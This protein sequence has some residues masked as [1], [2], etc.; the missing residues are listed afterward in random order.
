MGG[1]KSGDTTVVDPVAAYDVLATHYRAI[2]RPRRAY[3][4]KVEDLVVANMARACDLLD[5]GSG[6]GDRALRIAGAAQIERV[7]L[8][9]PSAGMRSQCREKVEFWICRAAEIPVGAKTF[10]AITC[11]WNVLGHLEGADERLCVLAR[12]RT[13]LRPSGS[14]FIDVNYR[15][16][17]AAY[18]WTKT[19]LRIARDLFAKSDTCGDVVVTWKSGSRCLRTRGHVFTHREL[20]RL[21]E[22]AGLKIKKR[23]VIDYADG[24]ERRFPFFGNMLYQLVA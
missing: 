13:L 9:E 2:A 23:W 15:Y 21:F 3:L 14:I 6:D 24:S 19:A 1:N 7:V 11:L 18:G 20:R 10:D 22:G 12:M 16:N 17:A 5:V 8:L 4:R